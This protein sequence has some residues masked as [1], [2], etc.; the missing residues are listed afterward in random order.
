MLFEFVGVPFQ[1]KWWHD[2]FPPKILLCSV[3]LWESHTWRL[4]LNLGCFQLVSNGG[5]RP[6]VHQEKYNFHSSLV[7]NTAG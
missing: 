4:L 6:S 1:H 5:A 7:F 2:F 3:S